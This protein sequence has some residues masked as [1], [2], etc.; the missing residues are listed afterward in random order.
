MTPLHHACMNGHIEAVKMLV[1]VDK[2]ASAEE[3][4]R[5]RQEVWD[6]VDKVCRTRVMVDIYLSSFV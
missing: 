2:G 1:K 5:T 3:H 6:A 4:S